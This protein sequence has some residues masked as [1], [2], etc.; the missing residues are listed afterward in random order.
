MRAS[1]SLPAA[2]GFAAGAAAPKENGLRWECRG[3]PIYSAGLCSRAAS[4]TPATRRVRLTV[5]SSSVLAFTPV[6]RVRHTLEVSRLQVHS[7]PS[8]QELLRPASWL[9]L[10]SRTFTFELRRRGRPQSASNMTT[11]INSQFPRPDFHRQVQRHYGLQDTGF[12]PAESE[13]VRPDRRCRI[14]AARA[15]AST[16]L[17]CFEAATRI[18][19]NSASGELSGRETSGFTDRWPLSAGPDRQGPPPTP[20][21]EPV[22]A[23][24][25]RHGYY[26]G[27]KVSHITWH[28]R[29]S[30]EPDA[31]VLM[32]RCFRLISSRGPVF[33]GETVLDDSLQSADSPAGL[34]TIGD[35]L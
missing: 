1:E 19:R 4:H 20:R 29:S 26:P 12:L 24:P 27:K 23:Q 28:R 16:I 18:S 3:S 11:W 8:P 10:L 22:T 6:S 31:P 33:L 7:F 5:S 34:Q 25:T 2:Y 14:S 15:L 9:A 32:L 21:T 13:W 17:T 35:V 30:Y